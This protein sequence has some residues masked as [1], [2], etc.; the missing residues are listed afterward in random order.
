MAFRGADSERYFAEKLPME[1]PVRLKARPPTPEK[2]GAS[3]GRFATARG[4]ATNSGDL[5]GEF[6][7]PL[8]RERSE[9]KA[10][11]V[12]CVCM[13]HFALSYCRRMIYETSAG[14]KPRDNI[15][16]PRPTS[17]IEAAPPVSRLQSSGQRNIFEEPGDKRAVLTLVCYTEAY[18]RVLNAPNNA[19]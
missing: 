10:V 18:S 8:R 1:V 19:S 12:S 17:V 2:Y 14:T 16:L 9:Q 5:Q 13:V 15:V 4:L 6:V 7:G 3:D 11:A